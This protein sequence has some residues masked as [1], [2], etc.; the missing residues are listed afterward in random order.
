MIDV[1][2]D[3]T[4]LRRIVDRFNV[5]TDKNIRYATGRAMASLVKGTEKDLRA[6]LGKAS[7]GPIQGGA[8]RWTIGAAYHTRPTPTNLTAEV[9]LRGDKPRAAGRYISV[10]ARGGKPR[11]KA[12]DLK[13]SAMVGRTGLRIVP[14]PGQRLDARGNVTRTSFEKA[15]SG[16]SYIRGGRQFNRTSGSRFFIIPIK[17]VNGRMGVF[18]RTGRAGRGAYGSFEGTKMRFTLEPNPK[19]RTSTY[20]ITGHMAKTVGRLWPGEI[21]QQLLAELRRAKSG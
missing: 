6:D 19:T 1:E 5:L 8:T 3:S 21:R 17:G 2:I 16:A 7:G 9:G 14:T 11:T 13:A 18:E 10:L 20:D 4:D 12:V 15:L